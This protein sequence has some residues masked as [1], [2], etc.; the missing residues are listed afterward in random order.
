MSVFAGRVRFTSRDKFRK[1]KRYSDWRWMWETRCAGD[2]MFKR[3]TGTR[4]K[5]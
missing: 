2:G 3:G 4:G 1:K 5:R